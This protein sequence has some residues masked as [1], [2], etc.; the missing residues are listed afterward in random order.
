MALQ[1]ALKSVERGGTIL[2]FALTKDDVSLTIP[3]NEFFSRNE[4]TITTSYAGSPADYQQALD[5]IAAHRVNIKDMITHRLSL[6]EAEEGFKLVAEAKDCL[7]V[8]IEPQR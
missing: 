1:Q 6:T 2:I 3:V 5:L 4:V 7:K 8:I